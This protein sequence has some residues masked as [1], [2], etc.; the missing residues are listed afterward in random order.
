M[1]AYFTALILMGGEGRRLGSALPKQF[2]TLGPMKV[3]QHTLQTFRQSQLFQEIILV[4]H[5]DWIESVQDE[6]SH[7]SEVKVIAG[8]ETRQ[9]SSWEGLK[10]CHPSCEYV[11]IHDAV[12]PFVSPDILQINAEAVLKFSAVDT[13]IPSADTLIIT[14]DGSTI[15]SIPPRQH[16]RR[17]QTPQTF[18]YPLICEAHEKATTTSATDDCKLV[19]D[20]GLPVHLVEGSEENLKITTEWDLLLAEHLIAIDSKL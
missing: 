6:T 12:R 17:G 10:A 18:A 2:H 14:E 13:V 11:M 1:E 20:L 4:C 19:L 9:S 8:G 3:Y 16:F 7:F 15:A 5:P